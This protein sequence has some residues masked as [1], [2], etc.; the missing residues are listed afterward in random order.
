MPYLD[1]RKSINVACMSTATT[2]PRTCI[3]WKKAD[4]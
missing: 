4:H 1:M 3:K 2:G